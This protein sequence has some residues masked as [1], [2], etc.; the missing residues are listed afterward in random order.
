MKMKLLICQFIL[1]S[2]VFNPFSYF[3]SL[4]AIEND[5]NKIELTQNLNRQSQPINIVNLSISATEL[6][7]MLSTLHQ[8]ETLQTS[9]Y[10]TSQETLQNLGTTFSDYI[11][12][13][14]YWLPITIVTCAYCSLF[15]K[16]TYAHTILNSKNS[17]S[18][19]K[20]NLTFDKLL[21]TTQKD[22]A[23]ELITEIQKKYMDTQNPTNFIT[24]MVNFINDINA[25]MQELE[26][27][28][29]I[30]NLIKTVKLQSI[31]PIISDQ[32][33]SQAKEKINKLVYIKNIFSEW[34][35]EFKQQQLLANTNPQTNL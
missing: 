35:V 10:K 23:L 33:L 12:K 6:K 11:N 9:S 14:K 1:Q 21:S 13:Y 30:I 28:V 22:L 27:Y 8:V 4:H 5:K 18:N 17:W 26:K 19:W 34:S 2:I 29:K 7:Q 3:N 31:Y 32:K 24:P 20:S 16:I 25:E 15:Y